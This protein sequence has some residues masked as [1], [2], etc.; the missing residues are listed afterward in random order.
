M[1]LKYS[2][3]TQATLIKA[4]KLSDPDAPGPSDLLAAISEMCVETHP[5]AESLL[6]V[7]RSMGI[8]PDTLK[9]LLA[10]PR[11]NEQLDAVM[12]RA[13]QFRQLEGQEEV[14]CGHLLLA[15]IERP[16]IEVQSALTTLSISADRLF[17]RA[18]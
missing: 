17:T 12:L 9:K 2:T 7:L 6:M 4:A 10:G 15:L 13:E 8:S 14:T 1:Q 5:E 16:N 11:S 18:H 3:A